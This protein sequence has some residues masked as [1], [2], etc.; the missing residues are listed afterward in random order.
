MDR[1]VFGLACLIPIFLLIGCS[2]GPDY[3]EPDLTTPDAW[4]SAVEDELS[5]A[6]PALESWWTVF[7]DT[8]L[9]NLIAEADTSNLNLAVAV[10]RLQEA[11]AATGVAKGAQWPSLDAYGDYGR[12]QLSEQSPPG[13]TTGGGPNDLWQFGFDATWEIDVF[14]KNRRSIEAATATW[15]ASVE[16]YRDVLVT[17]YAEVAANYINVRTL[18]A[19]IDY[20][21]ANA[22]ALKATMNLTRDRYEA[23][24]TSLLDVTR[25]ESNWANTMA[26]IPNLESQLH[27]AMNRL[28]VLLGQAPGSLHQRLHETRPLP[29]PP[30]DLLVGLPNDL[31][32]RRPDVRRAERELAAQTARVGVATA[33]LYPSFSIRGL[34][35]L[36]STE[37]SNLGPASESNTWSLVPGFRWNL[38]NG[39]ATRSRIEIEEAR[40]NQLLAAYEIAVLTALEDVENAMMALD[41]ERLRRDRLRQAV[42]AS[43]TSVNLVHTQYISG[44]TDFQNYLDAQRTLVDEQD[45]LASSEGQ[46]VQNLIALNKALGGG[47]SPEQI[48]E[49]LA[50]HEEEA[51]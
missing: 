31:L 34:L 16:D 1:R 48:P 18:Q 41:R 6:V 12:T 36:E 3:E 32:R 46:V 39:G 42:A 21:E 14:G 25:A 4:T 50:V 40:T 20:A 28:A 37:W 22:E 49:G 19:R 35:G 2:V 11:R 47:W 13:N 10:G 24:L 51:E 38:F 23:G 30:R 43:E 26:S 9:T 8:T 29:T 7:G 5:P 44:L 27:A 17:L 33:D 45:N 15:Q